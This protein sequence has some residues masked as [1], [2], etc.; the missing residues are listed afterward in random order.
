MPKLKPLIVPKQ[1]GAPAYMAQ[2]TILYLLLVVFFIVLSTLAKYPKANGP[3]L[4]SGEGD[5]EKTQK[6]RIGIV[7]GAPSPVLDLLDFWNV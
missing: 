2:F 4:Y 7:I 1:V 6:N 3:G 5:G